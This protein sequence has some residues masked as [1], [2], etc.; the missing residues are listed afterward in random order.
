MRFSITPNKCG[1]PS[2]CRGEQFSLSSLVLSSAGLDGQL[3]AA[4][5][6]EGLSLV[7]RPFCFPLLCWDK[8]KKTFFLNLN[9]TQQ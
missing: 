4:G 1:S 6:G 8:L 2:L 9:I 3:L 7:M 5:K